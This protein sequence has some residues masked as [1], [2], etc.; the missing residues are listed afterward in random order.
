MRFIFF[1]FALLLSP[2]T[3]TCD[4]KQIPVEYIRQD[5]IRPERSTTPPPT[6]R[7]KAKWYRHLWE[8]AVYLALVAIQVLLILGVIWLVMLALPSLPVWAAVLI[9]LGVWM[10]ILALITLVS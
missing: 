8:A 3:A 10:G 2:V 7:K 4:T 5:T 1:F 6:K 9:G